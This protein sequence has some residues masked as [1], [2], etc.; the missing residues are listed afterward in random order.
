MFIS[1]LNKIIQVSLTSHGNKAETDAKNLEPSGISR[2][3]SL[4]KFNFDRSPIK[5]I[6]NEAYTTSSLLKE[7]IG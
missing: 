7:P 2:N 1:A 6:T 4:K 5:G 3:K